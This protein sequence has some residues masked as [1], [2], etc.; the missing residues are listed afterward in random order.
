MTDTAPEPI[1]GDVYVTPRY[2]AGSAWIGDPALQ[3]LF[4]LGWDRHHDEFGNLYV[5]SPDRKVRLGFLP[6]GDDD[7]LWR[8]TAYRDPFAAPAWGVCFN[9]M[10]PTELVT[11]FTT[12]LVASYTQGPDAYLH[13]DVHENG[14]E[15]V[16]PL[17]N[18]GWKVQHSG[19]DV[20]EL[21]TADGLAGLEFFTGRLDEGKELTTLQA[22]WYLWG[23]PKGPRWYA[24]ASTGTP[25][26]LV[27]AITTALA[28]PAP[29]P[30]WQSG[31]LSSLRPHIQLTP[32]VPPPP[33][34]PTPLD[35]HRR[36]GARPRPALTTTSVPRWS[37]SSRPATAR[38]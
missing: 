32:I 6:E 11:A 3:P 9:D 36:A 8:I 38:R 14:F 4:E 17:L 15:A 28:D 7:G 20:V 19:W 33:P 24:T 27:T 37:T 30:R 31:I 5:A 25:V 10:T 21:Q 23:G 1:D 35:V 13:T 26:H 2:L 34:A 16:A 22:R 29:V 12:T 18:G